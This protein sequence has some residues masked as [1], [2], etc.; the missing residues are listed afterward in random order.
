MECSRTYTHPKSDGSRRQPGLSPV[1]TKPGDAV[2]RAD[3]LSGR[4]CEAESKNACAKP[5]CYVLRNSLTPRHDLSGRAAAPW[6][7][8]DHRVMPAPTLRAAQEPFCTRN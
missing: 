4:F 7:G 5:P 6:D 3:F 2:Q 1:E 8:G